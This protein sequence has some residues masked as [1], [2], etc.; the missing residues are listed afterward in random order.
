MI[1]KNVCEILQNFGSDKNYFECL[2]KFLR[3]RQNQIYMK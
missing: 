3:S 2:Q 1:L